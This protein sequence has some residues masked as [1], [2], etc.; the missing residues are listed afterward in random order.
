MENIRLLHLSDLHY[1]KKKK[2]DLDIVT[3]SFFKNFTDYGSKP[4]IIIFSGDLVDTG[5]IEEFN[6]VK[7]LFLDKLLDIYNLTYDN[8]VICPGNHDISRC[9]IDDITEDGLTNRLQNRDSVNT[10]IDTYDSTHAIYSRMKNY[11]LFFGQLNSQYLVEHNVHY[12][13]YKYPFQDK[14]FGFA[15]INSAWRSYGGDIDYGKLLIGERILSK[16]IELLDSCDFKFCVMHHPFEN[17]KDFERLDLKRLTLGSFDFLVTGHTHSLNMTVVQQLN[18]SRVLHISGGALYQHRDYF[19]GYSFIEFTPISRSGIVKLHQYFEASRIFYP[20]INICEKGEIPFSL[21]ERIE[22]IEPDQLV[23]YSSIKQ[24]LEIFTSRAILKPN[25]KE[26]SEKKLTEIFVNPP[27]FKESESKLKTAL[28]KGDDKN[29][30]SISFEEFNKLEKNYVVIGDKESGKTTLL[31]YLMNSMVTSEN[32]EDTKIPLYINYHYLS[33]GKNRIEKAIS[34][35]LL[36]INVRTNVEVILEKKNWVLF[37]DD[38]DLEQNKNF[39]SV[40]EFILNYPNNNFVFSVSENILH[41]LQDDEFIIGQSSF[42]RCYIH[43][44]GRKEIRNLA[45]NFFPASNEKSG[46]IADTILKNITE[47]HLPPTPMVITMLFIVIEEDSQFQPINKAS[48]VENIINILLP[49]AE[50]YN[51]FRGTVDYRIIEDYFGNLA[52]EFSKR[53]INKLSECEFQKFSFDYFYSRGLSVKGGY[54]ELIDYLVNKGLISYSN[55]NYSFRFKG[56]FEFF[57]AKFMVNDLVKNGDY[58]KNILK[59]ENYLDF[60]GP[61][62]YLTGLQRNNDNLLTY[63]ENQLSKLLNQF[64]EKNGFSNTSMDLFDSLFVNSRFDENDDICDEVK[65]EELQYIKKTKFSEEDKDEIY[66]NALEINDDKE[67]DKEI[68][69]NTIE[70][71]LFGTL[72]LYATINKNC[73]LIDDILIKKHHLEFCVLT[74]LRI[75]YILMKSFDNQVDKMEKNEIIDL[76]KK[77]DAYSSEINVSDDIKVEEIKPIICNMN[78]IFTFSLLQMILCSSLENP[79]FGTVLDKIDENELSIIESLVYTKIAYDSKINGF[80]ERINNLSKKILKNKGTFYREILILNLGI[81]YSYTFLNK[82]EQTQIENI[83]AGLISKKLKVVSNAKGYIQNNLR[84][85]KNKN[86]K[87]F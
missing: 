29:K 20:A 37:I 21:I 6:D 68:N 13:I 41:E 9:L 4:E 54:Q 39:S 2:K 43:S 73:E 28:K 14:L 74:F 12:S 15:C 79:H 33:Q 75:A 46:E 71:K 80:I 62:D 52:I 38:F 49:R 24:E 35:Y 25:N 27:L 70:A 60:F 18:N 51:I 42:T 19:N 7:K 8:L 3:N 48:L 11:E 32:I 64:E 65:D 82:N 86:K 56:F 77:N 69:F 50:I 23:L 36:E 67:N 53:N 22:K 58:V 78:H 5:S 87:I 34:D 44:Y 76:I 66:T 30:L 17:L 47:I 81:F 61:F 40:S 83:L 59:D 84:K 72:F 63:L 26:N 45:D 31:Y 1:S 16:S 85:D 57:I 55:N 10:I